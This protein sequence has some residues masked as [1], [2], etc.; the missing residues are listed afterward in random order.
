MLNI[1]SFLM[2][3]D[4]NK[5]HGGDDEEEERDAIPGYDITLVI[6]I[7]AAMS[8]ITAIRVKKLRKK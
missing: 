7:I 1:K 5:D 2:W 3:R 8:I 6:T 4:D